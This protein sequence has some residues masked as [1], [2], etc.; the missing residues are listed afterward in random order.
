MIY[1]SGEKN[2]KT[3]SLIPSSTYPRTLYDPV[4][5]TL[6][7]VPKS[8]AETGTR[9]VIKSVFEDPKAEKFRIL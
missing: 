8:D 4:G 9:Y 6:T 7:V 1:L 2:G 3:L 5:S